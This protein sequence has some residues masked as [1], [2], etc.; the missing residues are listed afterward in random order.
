M[1]VKKTTTKAR[2]G[3]ILPVSRLSSKGQVTVPKEVRLALRVGPGDPIVFEIDV[4]VAR[5]RR[6]E[7]FDVELD[8]AL[9]TTLDEWTSREDDEAFGDL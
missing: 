5:M 3:R 4:N 1:E 8:A 6:L 7:P 9:W 2:R